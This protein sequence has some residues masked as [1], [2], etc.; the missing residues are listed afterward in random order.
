MEQLFQ[1]IQR[2]KR[3]NMKIGLDVSKQGMKDKVVQKRELVKS[4]S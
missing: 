2:L 4:E 3:T 1:R